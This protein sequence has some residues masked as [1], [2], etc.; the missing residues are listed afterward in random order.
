LSDGDTAEIAEQFVQ[1]DGSSKTFE[2][3]KWFNKRAD[4]K[5]ETAYY[6]AASPV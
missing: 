5:V 2:D 4:Y 1:S 6:E 3:I